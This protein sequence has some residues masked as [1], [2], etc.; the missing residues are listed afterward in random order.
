MKNWHA[1]LVLPQANG[2]L[3]TLL[4]KLAL[5]VRFGAVAGNC[6]R[7]CSQAGTMQLDQARLLDLLAQRLRHSPL[8]A[9][10][11]ICSRLTPRLAQESAAQPHPSQLHRSGWR[12]AILLLNYN[13]E[14]KRAGGVIA[15]PA[16]AISIKNKH[17]L[18]SCDTNPRFHG[19]C[20]GV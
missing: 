17:L 14:I 5:D 8:T 6:V 7:T 4:R 16:H 9:P 11:R 18:L 15:L 13:R 10:C 19:G 1:A 2:V 3:E 20:F 12:G